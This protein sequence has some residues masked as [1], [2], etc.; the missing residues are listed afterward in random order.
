[1][2][3]KS[4]TTYERIFGGIEGA[5]KMAAEQPASVADVLRN[6]DLVIYGTTHATNAIIERNTARTAF[7]VTEGFPDILVLR[8]GG[9]LDPFNLSYPPIEPYVPRRL[10]FEIRERIDS[11]GQVVVALDDGRRARRCGGWRER[12]V[13]AIAVCLL[14]SPVNPAHEAALGR[15]I[16]AELPGVPYTL[17]SRL[18]PIIREYRRASSAAIDASLKPLMQQPSAR[19]GGGPPPRRLWRATCWSRPRSA[20]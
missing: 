2:L 13:E 18:N 5:L 17:S 11:E 15:L 19:H 9:K 12:R 6:T 8:E 16:E 14:W 3:G 1:M 20:A 10:T 7:L 4:L